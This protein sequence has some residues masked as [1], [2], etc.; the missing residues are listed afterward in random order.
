[1]FLF[2]S[3]V[4]SAVTATSQD[5]SNA[6]GALGGNEF[7]DSELK[8]IEGQRLK[9]DHIQAALHF[10][11][12]S[13]EPLLSSSGQRDES[14]FTLPHLDK[15]PDSLIQASL[16]AEKLTYK[17]LRAADVNLHVALD[18][19]AASLDRISMSF[20]GGKA[21]GSL[22]LTPTNSGDNVALTANVSGANMDQILR[23]AGASDGIMSGELDAQASLHA[24]GEKMSDLKGTSEG[25]L[26]L[27][28]TGGQ[29][30]RQVMRLASVDM[31]TI[32]TK[33]SSR[34][35][36]SCL[37]AV[38]RFK[39]GIGILAPFRMKTG[40]GILRGGGRVDLS[41]GALDLRVQTDSGSTPATALDIPIHISGSMDDVS[42]APAL[43]GLRA[44]GWKNTRD[45]S[46]LP[47]NTREL[48][49]ESPCY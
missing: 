33:D 2:N 28:M 11:T 22:K 13:V 3:K 14:T 36:L 31:R 38:I 41:S 37:L 1:M 34:A 4:A 29:I 18:T 32:F 20:I 49:T 40:A 5:F 48:A 7:K 27:F 45:F 44:E 19:A 23:S 47:P 16:S 30:S 25:Y 21:T 8:L 12:L 42:A 15:E 46:F 6:R 24:H 26:A 35:N 10:G 17:K 39:G 9:P 43:G